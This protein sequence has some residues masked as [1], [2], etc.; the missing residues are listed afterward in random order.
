MALSESEKKITALLAKRN[1]NSDYMIRLSFDE[2]FAL[3][4]I[5]ENISQLKAEVLKE[6]ESHE[7]HIQ[8]VLNPRIV[9]LGSLLTAISNIE[10]E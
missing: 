9:E 10:G 3:S 4:E 2:P 8:D 1:P 7:K 6:K 5:S